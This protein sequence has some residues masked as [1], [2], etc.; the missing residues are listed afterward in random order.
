MFKEDH[1]LS[2]SLLYNYQS[3]HLLGYEVTHNRIVFLTNN[4]LTLVNMESSG[5]SGLTNI[6]KLNG[7][8]VV[9]FSTDKRNLIAI[10]YANGVLEVRSLDTIQEIKYKFT[11]IECRKP[12]NSP[13]GI[14]TNRGS[15]NNPSGSVGAGDYPK[16]YW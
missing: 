7:K 9:R 10:L 6:L 3:T 4:H 11:N 15:N 2:E 16:I 14:F 1:S 13:S 12:G 5:P 8:N